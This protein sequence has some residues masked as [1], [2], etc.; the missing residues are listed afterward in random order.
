MYK[1]LLLLLVVCFLCSGCSVVLAAHGKAAP[2]LAV[3]RTGATRGEIELQLGQPKKVTDIGTYLGALYEYEV[4]NEPSAGRAIVHGVADVFTLG[5]WEI[6]GTPIEVFQGE[7][8]ELT[9]Y[10]DR[11]D[12]ARGIN[13][14]PSDANVVPDGQPPGSVQ[15]SPQATT[16]EP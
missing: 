3:V 4:G 2:N 1:P 10:Y 5:L 11:Q 14:P 8:I 9:I 15:D 12:I 7:K 6:I 16:D 13:S